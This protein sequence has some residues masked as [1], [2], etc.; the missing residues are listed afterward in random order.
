L[1]RS[2]YSQGQ[3]KDLVAYA[4]PRSFETAQSFGSFL[5]RESKLHLQTAAL[6]L[7]SHPLAFCNSIANQLAKDAPGGSAR[8]SARFFSC[9][10]RRIGGLRPL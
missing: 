8:G 10:Q 5:R 6:P 9:I 2:R 3:I 7:S 1:A 4:N